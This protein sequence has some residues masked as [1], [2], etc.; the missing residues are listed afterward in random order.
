MEKESDRFEYEIN[1]YKILV[2]TS[3][4][5]SHKTVLQ[6]IIYR[7]AHLGLFS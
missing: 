4:N 1:N 7:G 6:N 5:K 2:Q 3:G